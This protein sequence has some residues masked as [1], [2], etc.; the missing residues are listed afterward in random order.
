MS[1]Y[2]FLGG[3]LHGQMREVTDDAAI[4]KV[5]AKAPDDWAP[6][7]N[8]Q[9][10]VTQLSIPGAMDLGLVIQSWIRRVMTATDPISNE[11]FRN[12]VYIHE[13]VTDPQHMFLV[14]ANYLAVNWARQGEKVDGA[15]G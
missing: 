3:D 2:L 1:E 15:Q 4:V 14:L 7:S 8:G 5:F 12:T 6:R 9:G 13:S 10:S 11:V